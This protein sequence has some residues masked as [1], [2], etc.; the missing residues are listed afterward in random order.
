MEGI[1]LMAPLEVKENIEKDKCPRCGTKMQP[2]GGCFICL[3]CYYSP[4]G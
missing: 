3:T 4:C 2:E 1:L